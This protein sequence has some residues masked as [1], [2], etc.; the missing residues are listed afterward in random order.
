[1]LS[2][3]FQTVRRRERDRGGDGPG[4]L[5]QGQPEEWRTWMS[6]STADLF[7]RAHVAALARRFGY[8]L[9]ERARS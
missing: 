1:M 6:P 9:G 4:I 8:H 7:G 2:S 3:D 5:R